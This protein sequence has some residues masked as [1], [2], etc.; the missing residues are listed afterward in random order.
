MGVFFSLWRYMLSAEVRF[1]SVPNVM[2]LM[3]RVPEGVDI[4]IKA[5]RVL[6]QSRI[7]ARAA[8]ADQGVL[9]SPAL[10]KRWVAEEMTAITAELKH[11]R[12]L[13]RPIN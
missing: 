11:A 8:R 9:L 1:L 10:V 2:T 7:S 6:L 12:E 13:A 5:L 4:D 3:C